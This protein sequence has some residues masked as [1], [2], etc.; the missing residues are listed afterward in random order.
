[1]ELFT[2]GPLPFATLEQ[3]SACPTKVIT[4]KKFRLQIP[5]RKS[6]RADSEVPHGNRL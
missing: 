4:K 3:F 6:P 2:T 1:M 5:G